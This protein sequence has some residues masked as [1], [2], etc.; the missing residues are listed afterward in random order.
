MRIA[1]TPLGM[2]F[3]RFCYT[4]AQYT[5]RWSEQ[6]LIKRQKKKQKQKQGVQKAV[7][8]SPPISHDH[9]W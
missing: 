8:Q 9:D 7:N 5:Q 4:D 3:I 1:L 6:G 2:H